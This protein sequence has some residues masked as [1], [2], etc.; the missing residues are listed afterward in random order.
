MNLSMTTLLLTILIFTFCASAS[1][2]PE[3]ASKYVV[4]SPGSIGTW[5]QAGVMQPS[6]LY[7]DGMYKMWYVGED[8]LLTG[9]GYAVSLDGVQWTRLSANALEFTR[10]WT[11]S[12]LH[13][14]VLAVPGGG[15]TM[16]FSSDLIGGEIGSANSSDGTRWTD[17]RAVLQVGLTG[18][19]D[20]GGVGEPTVV[21]TPSGYMMWFVGV[22]SSGGNASIGVAT[23]SDG[24]VWN[25][26]PFNPVLTPGQI[27]W[28][29]D[30]LRRPGAIADSDGTY[31]LWFAVYEES[32]SRIA[33]ASSSDGFSWFVIGAVLEKG[34]NATA[35]G[36]R[37][38]DPA[39][40]QGGGLWY[41]GFDGVT[42]RI[43][44]AVEAT[45]PP[46][47][48]VTPATGLIALVAGAGL[49]GVGSYV[50]SDRFKY[51]FFAIPLALKKLLRE[52]K[53]DQ[54]V[55]G[56]IYQYIREN[57]GDNYSSIMAAT[58][59]SNGNL[60]HHLRILVKEDFIKVKK[61]GRRVY[62]YPKDVP[63]PHKL[64][65]R[66]SPLQARMLEHISKDPDIRQVKL[67]KVLNEKKQTIAYNV[68][69]LADAG[70]VTV[71]RVGRETFIR[72][73]K[74]YKKEK[75]AEMT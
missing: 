55:R 64:G 66:F 56:Q 58:G 40:L 19:W 14:C 38:T 50:T 35:D 8:G 42:W 18:A 30:G 59:T 62:F 69:T 5:D 3:Y 39:P 36:D 47:S 23:S 63:I 70:V 43:L 24:L 32:S 48:I 29:V 65:I 53:L 57:P 16:W 25:K 21:R 15:Y 73:S 27:P 45:E 22:D 6:L 74:E 4:L 12:I 54:F 67:C 11:D 52:K 2:V 75:E 44:L 31:G 26:Y 10:V 17:T 41:S 28:V 37:T 13:P 46:T 34:A 72:L 71:N 61:D 33:W 51:A 49:V 9:V 7:E 60:T 20:S 1:S 68:W